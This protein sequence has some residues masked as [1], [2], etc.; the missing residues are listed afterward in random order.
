MPD[1]MSKNDVLAALPARP[2]L[3]IL[4][5]GVSGSGKTTLSQAFEARGFV[6]LS[7]DEVIWARFGRYGVDYP[8][9]DYPAKVAAGR[10][11]VREM[12]VG[13]MAA[14]SP[15]VVDSS[16]WSRAHRDDFKALIET[17]GCDWRLIYLKPPEAVLRERLKSRSQRFDANA[18][19]TIDDEALDGHLRGFEP[20]VGEGE[21]VITEE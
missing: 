4:M 10:A 9:E 18:A 15:L 12:L 19:W 17:A 8:A 2:G 16:F 11:A 21:I 5:C 20:P 6:R 1:N 7:I 14:R 13:L 3:V